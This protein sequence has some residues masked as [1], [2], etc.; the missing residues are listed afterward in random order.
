MLGLIGQVFS[1]TCA[2]NLQSLP[3][4]IRGL[5]VRSRL[6]GNCKERQGI[7]GPS[8]GHC[9]LGQFLEGGLGRPRASG[10][11]PPLLNC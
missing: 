4:L 11:A 9:S 7:R 6:G 1:D 8:C 2:A 3:V 10:H 5:C